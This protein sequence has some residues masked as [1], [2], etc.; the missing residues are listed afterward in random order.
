MNNNM[1]IPWSELILLA[2]HLGA[3]EVL[4]MFPDLPVWLKAIL[5]AVVGVQS[6]VLD[7]SPEQKNRLEEAMQVVKSHLQSMQ[8]PA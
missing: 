1:T 8:Q 5:Q 2:V 3:A 4:K 7:L 6:G